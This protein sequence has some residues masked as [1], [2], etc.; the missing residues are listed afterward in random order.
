[1]KRVAG[2][3]H[4]LIIEEPERTAGEIREFLKETR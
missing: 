4:A 2:T 3:G 1:V